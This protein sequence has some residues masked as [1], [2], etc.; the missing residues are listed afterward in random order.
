M[1]IKRGAIFLSEKIKNIEHPKFFVIIGEDANN[2][3]GYFFINSSVNKYMFSRQDFINMQ[4]NIKRSKYD[5][6]LKY[7]SFIDCHELSKIKKDTLLEQINNK[8][9]EYK[10]ELTEEDLEMLM[11][12]LR[13]SDLY[14][15][16]EKDTFFNVL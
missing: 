4:M 16:V 3:V 7:D 14:S 2:F 6:F 8:I 13:K 10:G 9:T 5:S 15:K 12:N 11:E 1:Q